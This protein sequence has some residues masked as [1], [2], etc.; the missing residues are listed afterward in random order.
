MPSQADSPPVVRKSYTQG[1]VAG[2][3]ESATAE[4]RRFN[5]AQRIGRRR[6]MDVQLGAACLK[7]ACGPGA[8]NRFRPI[9]DLVPLGDGAPMRR[10]IAI[11]LLSLSACTEQ[12]KESYPSW[13]DAQRAGAVE[14]GWLPAFVPQSAREISDSHDLDS[15]RQTL[16]FVA[17]P[18]DVEAM[19]K[20][21][22]SVSIANQVAVSDLSNKHGLAPT[23]DAYKVC[24]KPLNGALVVDR[25]SGRAVYTT[26]V[27]WADEEC[28]QR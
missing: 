2:R 11:V 13:A 15:N 12:V 8:N 23:S 1:S 25:E 17:R 26:A 24:A 10:L 20:G 22:P 28:S 19:V 6:R 27:K 7:S 5:N 9:A 14:R 4:P 3:I 16:F 18:S 21:L